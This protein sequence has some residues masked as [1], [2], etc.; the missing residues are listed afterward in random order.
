MSK[1]KSTKSGASRA[2]DLTNLVSASIRISKT[3]TKLAANRELTSLGLQVN[4]QARS[5]QFGSPSSSG[6]TARQGSNGLLSGLLKSN[7]SSA[8]SGL[9]GGGLFGFLGKSLV[10]G[11]GDLFGSSTSELDPLVR[12]ELPES[13]NSTVDVGA[14]RPSGQTTA[15]PQVVAGRSYSDRNALIIRTVKQ[16]LLTSSQLNDIISEI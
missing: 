12:F 3:S 8:I 7:S 16:A 5:I 14:N 10:S 6:T 11:L 4:P 2:S 15:T 1:R 13:Q 9:I